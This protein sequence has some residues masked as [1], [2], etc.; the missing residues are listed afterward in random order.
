MSHIYTHTL[1]VHAYKEIGMN[2]TEIHFSVCNHGYT[3][4]LVNIQNGRMPRT[5]LIWQPSEEPHHLTTFCDLISIFIQS[6]PYN[7]YIL[8]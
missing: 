1:Y 4:L 8:Y 2:S 7:H 6:I 3:L 5:H